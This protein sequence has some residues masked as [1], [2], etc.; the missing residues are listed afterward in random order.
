VAARAQVFVNPA[1]VHGRGFL[2]KAR[3]SSLYSNLGH[4]SPGSLCS[5]GAT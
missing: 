5:G 3:F 2:N 4:M 1:F